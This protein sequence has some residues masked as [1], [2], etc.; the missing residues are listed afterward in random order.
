MSIKL[1]TL[2]PELPVAKTLAGLL[3]IQT[4]TEEA[5]PV[6]QDIVDEQVDWPN[7]IEHVVG[8]AAIHPEG[9]GV[10]LGVL[11]GVGVF[12][13]VGV[14]VRV[15]VGVLVFVGVGVLVFV[16]VGVRVFVGVGVLV[17]VGVGPAV[18]S[19]K[20]VSRVTILPPPAGAP[21]K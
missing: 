13:N 14:G 15:F 1:A 5:L 21:F 20:T 18:P 16:G 8:F 2:I 11:V 7:G 12:V 6:P 3:S 4:S 10:G 19:A 17:N 9:A